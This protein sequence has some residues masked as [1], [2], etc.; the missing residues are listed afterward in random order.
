MVQCMVIF[1]DV[2]I[3]I[4]AMWITNEN[5]WHIGENNRGNFQELQNRIIGKIKSILGS[6]LL[7]M[8]LVHVDV[9][10]MYAPF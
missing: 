2:T 8:R 7:G 5:N 3:F 6:S 4:M 1:V 9:Q 10:I